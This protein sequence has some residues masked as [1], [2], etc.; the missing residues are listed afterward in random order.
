MFK[1][2]I[3]GLSLA[4]LTAGPVLAQMEV[5]QPA[6]GTKTGAQAEASSRSAAQQAHNQGQLPK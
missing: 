5:S 6:V 4:L 1:C 3:A 2:G